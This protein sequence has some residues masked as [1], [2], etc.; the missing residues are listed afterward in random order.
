M[1]PP[2]SPRS[3]SNSIDGALHQH[4]HKNKG[5]YAGAII[6]DAVVAVEHGAEAVV[7]V[8][9]NAVH[10]AHESVK[11]HHHH[12]NHGDYV[13]DIIHNVAE[14]IR[15]RSNSFSLKKSDSKADGNG[16]SSPRTEK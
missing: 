12:K 5:D 14:G 8:A 4:S 1:D 11:A 2:R 7:H 3:R 10:N 9:A 16:A 6:H 13:A 15:S